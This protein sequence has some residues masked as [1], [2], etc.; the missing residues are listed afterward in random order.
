MGQGCG[1]G[2]CPPNPAIGGLET[3]PPLKKFFLP[4]T[5]SCQPRPTCPWLSLPLT[6]TQTQRVLYASLFPIWSALYKSQL[7]GARP[8]GAP[9]PTPKLSPG[10]EGGLAPRG[11]AAGAG[12]REEWGEE[13]GSWAR[14][15]GSP[16]PPCPAEVPRQRAVLG[17]PSWPADTLG[18]GPILTPHI[19][20]HLL[21]LCPSPPPSLSIY[22]CT[23]GCTLWVAPSSSSPFSVPPCL[24]PGLI[25]SS[26]VLPPAGAGG[27]GRKAP[28]AEQPAPCWLSE[29]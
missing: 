2:G 28:W 8:A 23:R 9:V 3:T 12:R 21:H 17:N 20:T 6:H 7:E 27:V 29:D 1:R 26:P 25:F 16:S 11:E 5:T 24:G 15:A 4:E 18:P 14:P 22:K 13:C 10:L 19:P